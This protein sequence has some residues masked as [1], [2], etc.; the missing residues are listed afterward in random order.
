MKGGRLTV[1][2]EENVIY[3]AHIFWD[4]TVQTVAEHCRRTA[5]YASDS[6]KS[7]GLENSVYL[8]GLLHDCGKYSEEFKT[9]IEKA[10]RGEPVQKGSVIH[11]FAGA[12]KLLKEYHPDSG[13][14]INSKL[15]AEI[16]ACAI[17]SHH[18]LMDCVNEDGKNG[19]EY[20]LQKQPDYDSDADEAFRKYC[21]ER[22][23]TDRLFQCSVKE[24]SDIFE[25]IFKIAST[26]DETLFLLGMLT[27][28]LTSSVIEGDRRDTAEFMGGKL[29]IRM[30]T[31][32]LFWEN[33]LAEIEKYVTAFPNETPIQKARR[34]LS[35]RCRS[36][37]ETP[38]GI[39]R[40]NLPTGAGKTL[41]SLRYAAA[42]A[43][44]QGKK[45]IIYVAPLI[46]ILDQNA[47]VIRTAVNN[48]DIVLEHH[49]NILKEN[50]TADEL[51]AYELLTETWDA[52]IIV[53]T[54]VQMLNT[55]FS[56]KTSC[57]RRMHS[58]CD[59]VIIF[60]EVQTVPIRMLSLFNLAL[61]FLTS[62]CN[63]TVLLCSATQPALERVE[64]RAAIS[65]RSFL[66]PKEEKHYAAL[67]KRTEITNGGSC[68]FKEIPSFV[69][70]VYEK[71][72]SV[73]VVCN[74][75]AE[76]EAL[77]NELSG[78][79]IE[80][81]HLSAAM[82]QANRK[83]VLKDI[84]DR[85]DR[86]E[87]FVCVST[88]VIEAGVD[89]SFPS[90]IRLQAGL[91]S[92]VQSAGRCNRN[93]ELDGAAPVY[94]LSCEDEN[95]DYLP[96]IKS[97]RAAT[98]GLLVELADHPE[99]YESGLGSPEAVDFYYKLLYERVPDGGMDYPVDRKPSLYSLL[100]SNRI[101]ASFCE[102]NI[103]KY[104]LQQAFRTAGE[105]FEMFDNESATVV[106][107]YG[108]GVKIIGELL[109]GKA[110][111]DLAYATTLLERAKPY[112]VSVYDWQLNNLVNAG[113]VT[114]VMD[115][116]VYILDRAYYSNI[117]GIKTSLKK[118]DSECS[119]L[120]L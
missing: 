89:I 36:F 90:V 29:Q 97:A 59:S 6:L 84:T 16:L 102:E 103:G 83:T 54:L 13:G 64:H 60:D 63:A 81:L 28:L 100:S 56:G 74:K 82:C 46:S 25:A 72:G 71:Y 87:R 96:D 44:S 4:G 19:Y 113:A 24:V 7:V 21:A 77:A 95:L 26:D 73:L 78:A 9:Y 12:C 53:T 22:Q 93:G 67:F 52:P 68:R 92:I 70:S 91:D 32:R 109:S 11:S 50:K 98:G 45:R 58:L 33:V 38:G 108:G 34:E 49:S 14:D 117:T 23:E 5:E 18:G 10:V 1:K 104:S 31:D 41:S 116:S 61:N 101:W 51:H 80:T 55:L 105:L 62:V 2:K 115:G 114:S 112:T 27:R 30:T 118:E 110:E 76:S 3:P 65:S 8:A 37:A 47:A 57:V 20:R 69:R 15:T 66:T 40:L 94:V 85:L 75:K 120:I 119:I 106:V 99:Q 35:D 43:C 39:F 79:G 88:Q 107:P 42:H 86:K 111:K 17:A 48:P